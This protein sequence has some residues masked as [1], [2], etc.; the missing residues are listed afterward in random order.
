MKLVRNFFFFVHLFYSR[1]VSSRLIVIMLSLSVWTFFHSK[2]ICTMWNHE[3]G[4]QFI[5]SQTIRNDVKWGGKLIAGHLKILLRWLS[6]SRAMDRQTNRKNEHNIS[7][8]EQRA[9]AHLIVERTI[10]QWDEICV[11]LH[12]TFRKNAQMREQGRKRAIFRS[13]KIV[14]SFPPFLMRFIQNLYF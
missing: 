10:S 11:I 8:I 1:F 12:T 14:A 13:N 3:T 9:A 5:M 4:Q 6:D 7:R 2:L